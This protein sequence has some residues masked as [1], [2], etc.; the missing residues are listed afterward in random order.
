MSSTPN[1]NAVLGLL[2]QASNPIIVFNV[3]GM[4]TFANS[5]ARSLP[6]QAVD[7]LSGHPDVK[8]LVADVALGKR[9][10]P[11][12]FEVE[13]TAKEKKFIKG[14]CVTGPSG[15]DVAFVMPGGRATS[16]EESSRLSLKQIMDM[17]RADLAPPVTDLLRQLDELPNDAGDELRSA[18][19]NV[20]ERL[21]RL[22]DLV[23][24]F[25]DDVLIPDE[26]ILVP[27]MIR[28]LCQHLGPAAE[29]QKI[30]FS[31]LG[32]DSDLPPLYGSRRLVLRG[33]HEC[34]DNAVKHARRDVAS[35]EPLVVEISLRATGL[36]L[37]IGIR[38]LGAVTPDVKKRF[39]KD[40]EELFAKA[41][42][43]QD[44]AT[45]GS[46]LSGG[47]VPGG[48]KNLRIGLPMAKRIVQLHGGSLKI[49]EENPA[50]LEVLMEF[51]TGAPQRGGV[52]FDMEQAQAYAADIAK[53]MARARK[54]SK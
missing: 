26:R 14:L 6:T 47:A 23:N 20:I 21:N 33:L 37:L 32:T 50:G 22:V 5:V 27:D 24:T 30:K 1:A 4:V 36:H 11:L 43:G 29:K 3:A 52:K 18:A 49:D 19:D 2:E 39:G 10:L 51:P 12:D 25:G 31:V 28:V 7:M 45:K 54:G 16:D 35:S 48:T 40:T 44:E 13:S 46:T 9:K 34:L 15:A 17:L 53:L 8:A 38:N 42:A 41:E